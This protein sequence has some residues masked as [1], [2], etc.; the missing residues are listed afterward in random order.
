MLIVVSLG[1]YKGEVP[2]ALSSPSLC[3]VFAKRV[4]SP[5]LQRRI[6]ILLLKLI[7]PSLN[8]SIPQFANL[9]TFCVAFDLYSPCCLL[10]FG[11]LLMS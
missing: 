11:P 8:T 4:S 1:F 10:P 9:E 3:Y 5:K 6:P 7:L 2:Y